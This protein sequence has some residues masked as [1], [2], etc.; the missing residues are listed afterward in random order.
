MP[1]FWVLGMR[2]E[3]KLGRNWIA[4]HFHPK[5]LFS[6]NFSKNNSDGIWYGDLKLYDRPYQTLGPLL[7]CYALTH[8]DMF[9]M[10]AK[11]I[12]DMFFP[13]FDV[14]FEEIKSKFICH[15]NFYKFVIL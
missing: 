4:K 12:A 7:S 3:F 14:S 2:K 9:L 11:E 6:G 10:K 1:T 15:C 8:D 13:I 5:Q